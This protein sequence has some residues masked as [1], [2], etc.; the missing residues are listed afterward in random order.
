MKYALVEKN[1]NSVNNIIIWDGVGGIINLELYT[2]IL[3]N[4]NEDCA[5]GYVYD[6]NLLPRFFAVDFFSI[7]F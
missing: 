5:V 6:P 4:E 1:T 3:L 2:L 7:A